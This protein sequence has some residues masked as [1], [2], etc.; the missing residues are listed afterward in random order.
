MMIRSSDNPCRG[1]KSGV[2]T[3]PMRFGCRPQSIRRLRSPSWTNSE[4]APMPPSRF[5]SV[6]FMN[7]QKEQI[8]RARTR[9]KTS[10]AWNIH[11]ERRQH[12]M[13]P[14][15]VL[16]DP[17]KTA[18][19]R[20]IAARHVVTVVGKL[21]AGREPRGLADNLV[22]FNHELRAVRVLHD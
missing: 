18:M 19:R 12:H 22:A 13:N 11:F 16:A 8:C 3:R 20:R 1:L 2:A 5:R 14:I 17:V 21:F 4:L 6:S 9:T 15:S 7:A 10:P